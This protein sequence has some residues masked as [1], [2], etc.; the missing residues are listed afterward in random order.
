M[1]GLCLG[2]GWWHQQELPSLVG[3]QR[4]RAPEPPF[5]RLEQENETGIRH[6]KI[7]QRKGRET[8]PSHSKELE[9]E[10]TALACDFSQVP[11]A[12]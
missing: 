4:G 9:K 10:H 12:L 5:G 8:P 3:E 11:L 7:S 6:R 1:S 2:H